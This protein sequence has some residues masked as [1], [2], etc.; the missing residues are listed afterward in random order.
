[1]SYTPVVAP[2]PA[3]GGVTSSDVD[4]IV[5]LTQAEYDALAPPDPRILYVI[6]G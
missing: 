3:G 4:E 1:M 6:V 5:V 2:D